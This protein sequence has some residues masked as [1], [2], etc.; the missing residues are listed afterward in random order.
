MQV[1]L[2]EHRVLGLGK[3]ATPPVKEVVVDGVDKELGAAAVGL[4]GVRHGQGSGLCDHPNAPQSGGV[5]L[6]R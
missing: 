3:I 2:S 1:H 4:T 5:G 6:V